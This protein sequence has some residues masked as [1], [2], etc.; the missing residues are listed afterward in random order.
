[1]Y[2]LFISG[3]DSIENREIYKKYMHFG[4]ISYSGKKSQDQYFP[5]FYKNITIDGKFSI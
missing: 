1:M 4:R 2:L 3:I 5:L